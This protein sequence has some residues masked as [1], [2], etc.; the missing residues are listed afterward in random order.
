MSTVVLFHAHPDDEAIGSGGTMAAASAQGHRVVLVIATRGE[1]GEP[2]EGV[3]ADGEE[4]WERRLSETLRSAEILGVHRVEFLGYV[5]SGM[6]GEP[7]N[8]SPY[9]FWGADVEQAA[10]RLAAILNEESA[11]V[12]T[13][14]DSH[15]VYG[16]P[17]H[18]QVHRV[19][20]R[21]AEI[22]GTPTVL[23]N[24]YN[25]GAIERQLESVGEQAGEITASEEMLAEVPDDPDFGSPEDEVTHGINV[26]EFVALKRAAMQAHESQI[27]PESWFLQLDDEMFA[28][29]FGIEWFIEHGHPRPASEPFRTEI[30]GSTR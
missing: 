19:G 4:L 8:D 20:L 11:D 17:D 12:L 5:D 24:T 26:A 30:F 7:A 15:G 18:I 28:A 22:A 1:R 27:G 13:V 2:R 9:S 25:R 21:A 16:H 23:E 10:T 14:Y 3:L 6:M 29:A